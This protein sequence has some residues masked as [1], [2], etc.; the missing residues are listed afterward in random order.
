MKG[1]TE[2]V[3]A[4]FHGD[5]DVEAKEK[6]RRRCCV[7][8]GCGAIDQGIIGT[9]LRSLGATGR[10]CPMHFPLCHLHGC[11]MTMVP[12]VREVFHMLGPGRLTLGAAGRKYF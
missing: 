1:H 7:S 8:E 5:A 12:F 10:E 11:Q 4:L 2:A 9:G 3:K 6:V